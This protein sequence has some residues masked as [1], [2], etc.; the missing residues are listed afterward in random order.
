MVHPGI[1]VGSFIGVV[2]TGVVL[3]TILKDE[4]N[5]MLQAFEK[6][7]PVGA[8]SGSGDSHRNQDN[9]KHSSD[10]NFYRGGDGSSSSSSM[11]DHYTTDYE[12]RQRRTR[13]NGNHDDE[14]E[15]EFETDMLTER[16]R[17]INETERAIAAN[18]ARLADMERSM[19]EREEALQRSISEREARMEQVEQAMREAEEQFARQDQERAALLN[20]HHLRQ[21]QQTHSA[22]LY[23]NP[24]ASHERLISPENV[25]NEFLQQT[26]S[27]PAPAPAHNTNNNTVSALPIVAAVGASVVAA[28][29]VAA[30]SDQVDPRPA[31]AIL[32]H[33]LSSNHQLNVNPF[34]DPSTLLDR[35]SSSYASHS[36]SSSRRSSIHDNSSDHL[37]ADA[38]DRSI[39]IGHDNDSEE[40]LDWTEAEI[41]SIG[42]SPDSED[43]W[44]SP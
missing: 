17:R 40:E 42:S 31:N 3:Y 43:S 24:F 35:A 27:S 10:D 12:L 30:S 21:Q 28:A 4:I 41:G 6:Q 19:K 23:Q 16:F 2:V 18:E 5:D 44:G 38:D 36:P 8:G 7:S 14:E 20:H 33:D 25:N 34:E 13:S 37:F 15:K 26:P 22:E 32:G 39:T 11:F 9:N 29:V 1:I